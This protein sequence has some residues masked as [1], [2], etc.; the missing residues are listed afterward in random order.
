M[1]PQLK[2]VTIMAFVSLAATL[3]VSIIWEFY[4]EY[5]LFG[6]LGWVDSELPIKVQLAHVGVSISLAGFAVVLLLFLLA[7]RLLRELQIK[8]QSLRQSHAEQASFASDVAHELRTPLAIM[9][10]NLD[11]LD[12]PETAK[13]LSED[14]DR[15]SRI[16]D[17]VMAKSYIDGIEVTTDD[18]VDLSEV[19]SSVATYMAPL[20]IKEGSTIEVLGGDQEVL[21][22]ANAFSIELALRNLVENAIKYSS[23]GSTITLEVLP[24]G[25]KNAPDGFATVQVIDHG[26]G[27]PVEERERIFERFRRADRRGNGSGMG[28]SIVR[29]VADAHNGCICVNDTP[30]GGATFGLCLRRVA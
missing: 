3:V 12:D 8:D 16:V 4:F 17:Q 19:V 25:R 24:Q 2:L 13:Q 5:P 23:R 1:T 27:V 26:C 18:Q 15:I 28:L 11:T 21:V 14:V 9:R 20:V 22:N 7:S 30:G 29:R 6:L 10:V